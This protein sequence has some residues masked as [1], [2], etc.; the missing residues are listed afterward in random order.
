MSDFNDKI[1]LKYYPATALC[2]DHQLPYSVQFDDVYFNTANGLAE[3]NYVFIDGNDLSARWQQN[4]HKANFVIAET[5]FGTGLNF[6][7]TLQKWYASA[8]KPDHLHYISL[9]KYP[10]STE[11]LL[12]AHSAFPEIE[13]YSHKLVGHWQFFSDQFRHG[14]HQIKYS[15]EITLT[16]GFGEAAGLLKQ[17]NAQI[18][19]W[20][21]DGFAPKKNPDMWRN[22]LFNEINRLSRPKST[23]ATFTAASQIK[24]QLLNHGFEVHKRKGFGKKREMITA[25]FGQPLT[26]NIIQ[27]PWHPTPKKTI[28]G[29]KVTILGAG[30]AGLCLAKHFKQLGYHITVIEQNSKPMKQA[31]GNELAMV[32]PM[33]TAENA[34]ESQFYI[35]AFEAAKRFYTAQEFHQIGVLQHLTDTKKQQWAQTIS[36]LDL[37][38]SLVNCNDIKNHSILYP[39]A[40][41]VDTEKVA[42]RL[43]KNVDQWHHLPI[44][45]I[46]QSDNG[47]WVLKSNKFNSKIEAELLII[48]NGIQAQQLFPA[49][50]LSMIGKHGMTSVIKSTQHTPSNIQLADGYII[51]ELSKNRMVCGATFDHLSQTQWYQPAELHQDHWQR[52]SQLWQKHEIYDDLKSANVTGAHAAIRATTPDHL[53]LCG[54]MVKQSQFK[55]DYQDLH[56]G[57]HWQQYPTAAVYDNLYTLNGLGSRGFTSAPLLAHYLSAMISGEPLPLEHDLCKIIHPNRFLYR[58]CKK[59]PKHNK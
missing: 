57:R 35:R 39:T 27:Q 48:A 9:E 30:I 26:Q 18:D 16:I 11:D 41:Y 38:E 33:L 5:G 7:A 50:E 59:P 14:L 34:P 24:K 3:S 55:Q 54:P 6:L 44:N 56:H 52:N 32:M 53:P 45:D 43:A 8:E 1:R 17:L 22:E 37:P 2:K 19:A 51:P 46:Q 15:N 49:M 40:G 20:Y 29:K 31:S 4:A 21:L 58:S 42:D 13:T 12:K 23:V 25:V 10:L 28:A 36:N 47:H